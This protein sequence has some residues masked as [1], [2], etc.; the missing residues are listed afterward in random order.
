M[1]ELHDLT[2]LEQARGIR[3]GDLSPVELT[4]H[5]LTRIERLDDTLGAFLTR[6][7]DIARKQ[8]ADAESEATTARREGRELPPLH[9]V[10]VPVKDLNQVAGVRCTMGSR[11]LAEHVPATDDHVVGKLRAGGTILLGKTNTPEFGLPCYTENGLAPPARTPWDLAR[12]AG[13]SSGGAAAAVAGGLAPV[14]HASDGGGSVRIP[15]SVCGLFGIKPS[16]GRISSGP[17][18]HDISGLATSGPLARTVADAATLLDVLAG[19][20]PGDPFAAPSLP[21]GETFADHA[22]RDPGRLRIACLTEAPV[23]GIE[24]HPDCRTATT[25]TAALLTGLGHEV[26]EL[27]LPAD[28][29]I[30]LAFTRVW[31]VLAASRPV[32]PAGEELLMPLTRY[33]RD[34]GAEVSG[35]DF[36]RSLYAFRM[37]AQSLADG[38]MPPGGYDVILSPTLAA[39]PAEV[40]AL[41]N[42]ADPQAEFDALG[43]FTPFTALYNATGQPAVNVPLQWNAAGLPIGVMLAGR[44]GDEATLIALSAQ[45]EQARPWAGRTPSVW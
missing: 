32:P 28:D 18:L 3:S 40:G 17:M 31:S 23:P 39:P 34:R 44:Y 8:A 4:E 29:S 20:M 2:A 22:L 19:P 21:L 15:A 5:Y 7:P 16:R 26:E 41:R 1:A 37:L 36:T 25:D 27:T 33:L 24:V 43:A 13:G 45:L 6:T 10:P 12:S 9:G 11:A 35:T 38:L 30:L 42:D 14:A